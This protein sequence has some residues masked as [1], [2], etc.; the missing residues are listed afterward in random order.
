M[1]QPQPFDVGCPPVRPIAPD[2]H[3]RAHDADRRV[4]DQLPTTPH[5]VTEPGHH[6]RDVALEGVGDARN[7]G[8]V[9]RERP[10]DR[11]PGDIEV[12]A[13]G[14]R[15]RVIGRLLEDESGAVEPGARPPGRELETVDDRDGLGR[16]H[17]DV[18]PGVANTRM[19]EP[20]DLVLVPVG[21]RAGSDDR[22]DVPRRHR[23]DH[24]IGGDEVPRRNVV[25]ERTT[26]ARDLDTPYLPVADDHPGVGAGEHPAAPT[27]H[28]AGEAVEEPG[29][30]AHRPGRVSGRPAFTEVQLAEI[31][32]VTRRV[33][34]PLRGEELEEGDVLEEADDTGIVGVL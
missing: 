24:G 34:P 33:L 9:G 17:R 10:R 4:E 2:E 28:Q 12:Q 14:S 30:S 32:A 1:R 25:R 21:E 11:R 15:R 29:P 3:R 8:R 19:G 16:R 7:G 13:V 6:R 18:H 31:E 27:D 26:A 5:G 22:G 20:A 23:H